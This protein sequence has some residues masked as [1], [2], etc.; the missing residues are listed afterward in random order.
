MTD[1]EEIETSEELESL[2]RDILEESVL[3]VTETTTFRQAGLMTDNSGLVLRMAD[4]SEYQLTIVKS[5]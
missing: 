4:G 3:Y 5:R 1:H 2:L